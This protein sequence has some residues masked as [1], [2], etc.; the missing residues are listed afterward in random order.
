[1][2]PYV[3][4]GGVLAIALLGFLLKGAYEE[5]GELTA[6]LETQAEQTLE[7]VD[8]NATNQTTIAELTAEINTMVEERR[9]DTERR[10]QVLE[11]RSEELAAANARADRLEDERDNEID[12]NP[13]CAD[14]MALSI[15][16]A[17]PASSHQLRQR[18]LGISGDTNGD[19][20]E[21][22]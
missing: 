8:A 2:N 4:G 7:A 13:E 20:G 1:M 21:T 6:K 3:L 15:D 10:E 19:S 22:G 18:S 5:N 9:V 11:E 14:I 17:C 12:T 16:A